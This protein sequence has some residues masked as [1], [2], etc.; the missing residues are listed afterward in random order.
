[1]RCYRDWSSDVCSSDLDGP[2]PR[3]DD[4]RQGQVGGIQVEGPRLL[5]ALEAAAQEAHHAGDGSRNQ[6]GT[7]WA[8]EPTYDSWEDHWDERRSEERRVGKEER[9][10]K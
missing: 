4:G 10:Q 7:C 6:G 2:D 9:A 5:Q 1:T 3:Q 8:A